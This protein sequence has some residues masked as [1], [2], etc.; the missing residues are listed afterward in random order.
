[1]G[2]QADAVAFLS[3]LAAAPY[4]YDF[5]ETLRRLECVYADTPR[6]GTARRPVD[7]RVRL[8]QEPALVFAPAPLAGLD[9]TGPVPQLQVHLFGLLGPN[10][11]LPTHITEYVRERVR[12][13]GDPTLSRFLNLLQHR[14]TALFYRAWAQAQPHVNR[15]RPS[16]DRFTTYVGA[17]VGLAP[18]VFRNRDTVPDL[19]KFHLAAH[20]ARLP[21]SAEGLR[22]ILRTFFRVPVDVQEFAGGWLQLG[23]AERTALGGQGAPLGAGA[24]LGGRVWDRQHKIRL[25]AGPLSYDEYRAFLPAD[26]GPGRRGGAT[27]VLS[28]LVDWMRFYLGFELHWDLRLILARN[29]VP[30]LRLGREGR[31]GWTSWLGRRDTSRD[32]DDVCLDAE[33]F[34]TRAGGEAI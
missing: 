11:P 25:V 26:A 28:Q 7:E 5:Y 4:R 20:L 29:E 13:A 8:G 23:A 14:L 12:H 15:D 9:L 2:R 22:S 32:A 3:A 1:M 34:V 6:L 33:A 31:L 16:E 21:R 18:D 19:A 30:P 27:A 17:F 10:G 24:V